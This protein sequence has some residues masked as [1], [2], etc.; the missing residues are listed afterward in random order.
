MN[1]IYYEKMGLSVLCF[2]VL[3]SQ[4]VCEFVS[5]W[6]QKIAWKYWH[7]LYLCIRFGLWY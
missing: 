2:T 6:K 3:N 5:V 7:Y 1:F 4:Y